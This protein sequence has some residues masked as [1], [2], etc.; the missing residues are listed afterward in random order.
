[1]SA[2][3][4]SNLLQVV[5]VLIGSLSLVH[6]KEIRDTSNIQPAPLVFVPTTGGSILRVQV[7]NQEFA[8][9]CPTS[10]KCAVYF[11][12]K[13]DTEG[14][15]ATC[16]QRYLRLIAAEG[17]DMS[18]HIFI[19]QN[20][21]TVNVQDFGTTRCAAPL[22]HSKFF[23]ALAA[24]GYNEGVNLF[25]G[26]WD[27]RLTIDIEALDP[28]QPSSSPPVAPQLV[29]LVENAFRTNND[30]RVVLVG[31]GTGVLYLKYLLDRM[32]RVWVKTY[33]EGLVSIAG[34]VAGTES[35]L[36]MVLRGWDFTT[37]QPAPGLVNVTE[38]FPNLLAAMP[39][40]E[41][42]GNTT[43][44]QVFTDRGD[45][46]NFTISQYEKLFTSLGRI[47]AAHIA[48]QFVGQYLRPAVPPPTNVL[49]FISLIPRSTPT[50]LIYENVTLAG[51]VLGLG[52]RVISAAST[53]A[54]LS[55][56]RANTSC[57]VK[58]SHMESLQDAQG[59]AVPDHYSLFLSQEALTHIIANITHG[60]SGGAC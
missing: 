3:R 13:T 51:V 4:V 32:P 36:N 44:V 25:V 35:S 9:D 45:T 39:D 18:S 57:E 7:A 37:M 41:W 12:A 47:E 42:F 17:R 54:F 38:T 11:G 40:P 59:P 50:T 22:Y 52:D 43:V 53:K 48:P 26:C 56:Q 34:N 23:P 1:M 58:V 8:P 33:V 49:A 27:W 2:F 46:K 55:W 10:A 29:M 6:P 16:A 30:T 60:W 5:I 15:S 21:V 20:G 19:N 28:L 14:V 31:H 24:A